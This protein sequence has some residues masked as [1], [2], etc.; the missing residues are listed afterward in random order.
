[1]I[2]IIEKKSHWLFPTLLYEG[3]VSDLTICDRLEKAILDSEEYKNR[4]L[5]ERC[6]NSNDKLQNDPNFKELS[7]LILSNSKHLL[8]EFGVVRDSHYISN[9]WAVIQHPSYRHMRHIHPNCLFSG[10]FYVRAPENCA[11][12][13]FDNPKPTRT[14]QPDYSFNS[15]VNSG[16]WYVKPRAGKIMLWPSDLPHSV[17]VGYNDE[18]DPRISIAF[19]IMITGEIK[20][21]SA[22]LIL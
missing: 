18:N 13:I 2:E 11:N 1:M 22:N 15:A 20:T 5:E 14:L 3:Q 7:D 21:R 6:Y 19:N 8:D 9:M 10:I 4:N 16:T 12:I 17:D